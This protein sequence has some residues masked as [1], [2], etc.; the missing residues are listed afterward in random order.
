MPPRQR[1]LELI[2][3][4]EGP[5]RKHAS[6]TSCV[7]AGLMG[8]ALST[9][10][11]E[12][13][14]YNV[15]FLGRIMPAVGKGIMVVPLFVVF[16]LTW[17]LSIWSYA[18]AHLSDPG[19][20]PDSWFE[21]VRTAGMALEVVPARAEW[22]PA[23]ATFCKKC[24]AP[25]PERAHHCLICEI[26][27][28]RMDHHCPWINNC[29]GFYNHKFFLLLG[30]YAD[31]AC[32]I[33]LASSLPELVACIVALTD[34]GGGFAW[35]PDALDF[36][37]VI[38]FL[39][40]GF[41]TLMASFLLTQMMLVHAGL[42]ARNSTSIE[43]SYRNMSNPFDQGSTLANLAQIFGSYSVDWFLPIRPSRPLSDGVAFVCADEERLALTGAVGSG[44]PG[45][46]G[47]NPLLKEDTELWRVRY[48]VLMPG[49]AAEHRPTP[50]YF[51]TSFL[52][53]L[54]GSGRRWR[55]GLRCDGESRRG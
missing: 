14:V 52:G 29:V 45:Q 23:K 42:A 5:H 1:H 6:F 7:S 8:V 53:C 27:V 48:N 19:V 37:E 17:F 24:L 25:R 3:Q 18:M 13:I 39:I 51:P 34:A 21:W 2:P 16:N 28:M 12:A 9:F 20:I 43:D 55:E 50:D 35:L 22:Q 54:G 15:V 26:C 32:I 36:T 30:I 33:A 4:D 10:I 11:Y 44:M 38:L 46:G 40:F 31:L 41:V 49:P 47:D